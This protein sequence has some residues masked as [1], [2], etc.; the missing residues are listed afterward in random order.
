MNFFGRPLKK[1][2]HANNEIIIIII[3]IVRHFFRGTEPIQESISA[4]NKHQKL[5]V[6]G[7]I[8][9]RIIP[10]AIMFAWTFEFELKKK[11][12]TYLVDP[13]IIIIKGLAL[14]K[15]FCRKST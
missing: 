14:S 4:V 6:V 12:D 15:C 11:A 10:T 13:G 5:G 9:M 2:K 3:I 1:K 8:M 7:I